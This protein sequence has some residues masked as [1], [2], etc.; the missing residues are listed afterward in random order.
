MTYN[1]IMQKA[2]KR[3]H[4]KVYYYNDSNIKIEYEYDDIVLAKPNLFF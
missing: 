1:E 2:G 4:P 3:I